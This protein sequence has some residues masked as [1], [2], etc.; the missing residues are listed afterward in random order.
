M[1]MEWVLDSTDLLN[2]LA[3]AL[4]PASLRTEALVEALCPHGSKRRDLAFGLSLV[5]GK[6]GAGYLGAD[7]R[8]ADFAGQAATVRIDFQGDEVRD[9]VLET[10]PHVLDRQRLRYETRDADLWEAAA[11]SLAND[12]G[13]CT[14]KEVDPTQAEAYG[15][16]MDPLLEHQYGTA[17]YISMTPP[18]ARIAIEA[19]M[20]GG[21]YDLVRSVLR[22]PN[23]EAR[24]YA[25]EALTRWER[26]GRA[27]Q[28][29]DRAAI[30]VLTC[31]GTPILVCEG[32]LV[33]AEPQDVLLARF[34][35]IACL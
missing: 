34:T 8:I 31:Q 18:G 21:H 6:Q 17:C 32:C 19:L 26:Q 35:D 16:L 20:A 13:R 24:V 5:Q 9:L 2:D 27:I 11:G 28:A 1:N 3:A 12:L 25:V 33:Y 10:W 23:P 14:P 15:I 22:S 30:E 4:P 7:V 29:K